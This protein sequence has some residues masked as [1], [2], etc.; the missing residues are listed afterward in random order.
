MKTHA[1]DMAPATLGDCLYP[2]KALLTEH[3]YPSTRD[4]QVMRDKDGAGNAIQTRIAFDSR[5]CIAKVSG[6]ALNERR[7]HTLQVSP[8]IHL[9]DPWFAGLL[10][11]SC[12]P[13]AFLDTTYL[14]LWSVQPIP[15][16]TL[17]TV[18]YAVTEVA[19]FRQFPCQ[20]G[21]LNCRGWIAGRDEP[22][23]LQGQ[24]FMQRW[25]ERK[26]P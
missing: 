14:E 23:N 8:R 6:H 24:Q 16:G 22:L 18:D 7:Q 3:G 17:L 15:A 12:N 4:Y 10:R 1:M 13:N 2:F 19:L 11:H 20:C 21:E 9:Y 5:L 26:S 25:R